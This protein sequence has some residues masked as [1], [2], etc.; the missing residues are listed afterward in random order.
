MTE[1]AWWAVG[2][3]LALFT[4]RAVW[5]RKEPEEHPLVTE[6]KNDYSRRRS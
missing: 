6:W 5:P 3:T 4:I 2:I 1:Q